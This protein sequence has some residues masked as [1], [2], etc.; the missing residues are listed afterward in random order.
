MIGRTIANFKIQEKLGEGGMG[1]VF[2]ALDTRLQRSV[3]LKFLRAQALGNDEMKARFLR[4]ARAAAA[5]D[6]PNI[7]AVYEVEEAEGLIFIAMPCIDGEN[8]RAKIARGPLPLQEAFSIA[9]QIAMGLGVAHDRGIV[10]R[11][12]K[13]ENIFV[14][15]NG[16]VKILDFGLAKLMETTKIT[17]GAM[18]LGTA[19]YVAPEQALGQAVD[20]RSDIWALGVCLYEMVAGTMPFDG[21]NELAV[22]YSVVNE[23]PKP[24]TSR[25]SDAPDRLQDLISQMLR[26]EREARPQTMA[27]VL[28]ELERLE[29]SL[30]ASADSPEN[31]QAP[32]APSSA[33]RKR[34]PTVAI[35]PFANLSEEKEQGYFCE[36]LAFDLINDLAS[37]DGLRVLSRF[38]T[39]KLRPQGSDLPSLGRKLGVDALLEGSLRKSGNTIRLTAQLVD[40]QDGCSIW[41]NR[42]DRELNDVF[43][44]QEEISRSIARAL[45]VNLTER[46]RRIFERAAASNVDAYDFYLRGREKFYQLSEKSL[47]AAIEMFRRAIEIDPRYALA[48]AGLADCFSCLNMFITRDERYL[49]ESISASAKALEFGPDLAEAHASRGLALANNKAFPQAENAFDRAVMLDPNSYDANFLYGRVCRMQ[50]KL[51]KAVYYFDRAGEIDPWGF[52]PPLQKANVYLGL[53]QRDKAEACWREGVARAERHI[54]LHPED[55]RAL[56][57]GAAAW[58][59]LGEVAKARTWLDRS[60][61]VATDDACALYSFACAHSLAGNTEDAIEYFE[62]ALDTGYASVEWIAND[63]YLDP[64]REDPRFERALSKLG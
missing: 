43:A 24:L 49:S 29:K 19:S 13:A 48:F 31:G 61:S 26:K 41:S 16:Q 53:N 18:M 60:N 47:E 63:R 8:L 2:K 57:Y 5:L 15:P 51:E 54:D 22:L 25:V 64:I 23:D 1:I 21:D 55:F 12:V 3:A 7:C 38:A 37:V 40:V 56:N 30:G 4:E 34:A 10:H 17:V 33:S 39:H 52:E 44:I 50:G 11:D 36:G 45:E 59:M 35:L 62:R 20:H 46:E 28:E 27:A 14:K 58:I 9:K 42:Y 32:R 6:H